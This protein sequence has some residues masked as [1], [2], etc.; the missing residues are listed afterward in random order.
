MRLLNTTNK[1]FRSHLKKGVIPSSEGDNGCQH[2]EDTEHTPQAW[3][4]LTAEHRSF[5]TTLDNWTKKSVA[6]KKTCH[7]LCFLDSSENH[8]GTVGVKV[9]LG[10]TAKA[11]EFA[12]SDSELE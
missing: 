11:R 4:G 10:L 8:M 7:G 1:L 3:P 9:A 6:I 12:M 2:P 5:K